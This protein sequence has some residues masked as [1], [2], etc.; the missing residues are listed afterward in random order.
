MKDPVMLP[1][2]KTVVDRKTIARH[3][4]RLHLTL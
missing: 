3:L 1:S 4:L 2:S